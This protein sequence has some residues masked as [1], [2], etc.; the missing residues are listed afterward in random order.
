MSGRTTKSG[1]GG[2]Q[3]VVLAD[4]GRTMKSGLAAVKGRT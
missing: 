4:M 3:K 2:Q 1:L